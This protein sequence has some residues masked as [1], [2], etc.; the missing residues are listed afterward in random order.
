MTPGRRHL[1]RL[2][3]R[4]LFAEAL[5]PKIIESICKKQPA[6]H[7]SGRRVQAG[8]PGRGFQQQDC[9]PT[10]PADQSPD[11]LAYGLG[12]GKL[13]KFY[14]HNG[15]VPGINAVMLPDPVGDAT[16]VVPTSLSVAKGG[17]APGDEI[18]QIVTRHVD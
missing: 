12:I 9:R 5:W 6:G 1:P 8:Q 18:G 4:A 7:S 15:R 3:H 2:I 17:I 16:V 11:A 10:N 14:G 13:G